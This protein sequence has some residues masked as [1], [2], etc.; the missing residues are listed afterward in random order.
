MF[1]CL[2]ICKVSN[3]QSDE[4]IDI[5]SKFH[6][7]LLIFTCVFG[8]I[9]TLLN[10]CPVCVFLIPLMFLY[11]ILVLAH[12]IL[13]IGPGAILYYAYIL[14]AWITLLERTC[15]SSNQFIRFLHLA[16]PL[17]LPVFAHIEYKLFSKVLKELTRP[18]TL[19]LIWALG[20]VLYSPF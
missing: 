3:H 13:S 6:K 19:L 16:I 15:F 20:L 12:I 9:Q 17:I 7:A 1:Q 2:S 18:R 14:W 11:S 8:S 4:F 5:L 10:F